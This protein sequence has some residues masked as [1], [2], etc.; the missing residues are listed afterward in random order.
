MSGNRII[1]SY[2]VR[3]Q[4]VCEAARIVDLELK[5]RS[6]GYAVLDLG[7]VEPILTDKKILSRE[8]VN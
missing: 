8:E 6:V 7:I 4:S 3:A 2:R 5:D 1:D